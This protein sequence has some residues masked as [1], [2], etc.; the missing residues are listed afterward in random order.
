MLELGLGQSEVAGPADSGDVGGLAHGAFDAGAGGV[1]G[2]PLRGGLLG[3]G[4]GERFVQVAGADGD[5]PAL[6]AGTQLARRA[7]RARGDRPGH[8]DGLVLVLPARAPGAAGDPL[9]AGRLAAVEV[10]GERGLVIPGAGSG[11]RGVVQQ[12]R[13]YQGDPERAGGVHDQLG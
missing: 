7:G 9:R 1:A 2:F 3:A 4:G 5:L 6:A 10:D 13:G 12:Q 8:H 11:L